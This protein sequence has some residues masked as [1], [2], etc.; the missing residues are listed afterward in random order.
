MKLFSILDAQ[1]TCEEKMIKF[2]FYRTLLSQSAASLTIG[3]LASVLKLNNF[4]SILIKLKKNSAKNGMYLSKDCD[5]YPFIVAKPN[6]QD[7]GELLPLLCSAKRNGLAKRVFLCGPFASL[8]SHRILIKYP[9]IDGILLGAC[10]K[11]ILALAKN[12]TENGDF[13]VEHGQIIKH[14][15]WRD[16]Q[17]HKIFSGENVKENDLIIIPASNRDIESCEESY[18]ANIEFLRGCV[19]TCSFCHIPA[20]KKINCS[21]YQPKDCDSIIKEIESLIAIGKKVL[22][23]NDSVFY[24]GKCDEARI[25]RF[26]Q[27]IHE[28]EIHIK[29]MIYLSLNNFPPIEI[30]ELLKEAGLIRVFIGVESNNKSSLKFFNKPQ[31]CSFD[32]IVNSVFKP[33]H[34]SYHIGYIVFFPNVT[35]GEV[36][37][38]IYYLR[39]IKKIH[40]VGVVLE[41]MRLIPSTKMYKY[42]NDTFNGVDRAY[43]YSFV[44]QKVNTLWICLKIVFEFFLNS[45]HVKAEAMCTNYTLLDAFCYQDNPQKY[46][47]CDFSEARLKHEK[48]I[49]EY[50]KCLSNF[51][52]M[53]LE[54]IENQSIDEKS[55]FNCQLVDQFKVGFMEHIANLQ[56]TWAG[57][58]NIV[59]DVYKLDSEKLVTWGEE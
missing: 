47:Q 42:S 37:E 3:T 24:R 58:L 55:I 15:I 6:F 28:K 18:I 23:F 13:V 39:K 53:F 12:L 40:R 43:A 50:Q 52:E 4:D 8:N 34:I 19:N 31:L 33:L 56:I 27:L 32:D 48:S 14:G 20:L 22:I 25:L 1:L 45:W 46:V 10:E 44:D 49:D 17:S 21:K 7:Q 35:F 2:V 16:P 36:K 38:S 5:K 51:F 29:F 9:E 30:M 57:L 59:S 26:C 41:K 11:T 54:Q